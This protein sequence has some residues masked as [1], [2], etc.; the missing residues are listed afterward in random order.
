M[1]SNKDDFLPDMVAEDEPLQPFDVRDSSGRQGLLKLIIGTVLLLVIAFLLLK[2]YKPGTRDR[3]TPPRITAENTPFKV[4][5]ADAGGMQVPDQD[6]E[7]FDVMDGKTPEEV[8]TEL[9]VP[10]TPIEL[11]QRTEPRANIKVD[12][13]AGT[14]TSVPSDPNVVERPSVATPPIVPTPRTGGNEY[15]VQV[16]SVRSQSDAEAVWRKLES[17]F[18]NVL[19]SGLYADIKRVDLAEKGIY[20]RTRIA[21]LEDR[22]AA[23]SLC[24]V[25][26]ASNQACYVT[27]R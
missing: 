18:S 23:K 1:A 16:A 13:P 2:F 8:V 4:K 3:Q 21:G 14:Q 11:P 12:P 19:N 6:R 17:R 25:L 27:K 20:Y 10:E 5:P 15:V 22:E 9:K 26:K 7:V 24:N